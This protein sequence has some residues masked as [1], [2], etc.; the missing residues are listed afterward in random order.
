M[1]QPTN[2]VPLEHSLADFSLT[3]VSLSQIICAHSHVM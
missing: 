1:Q 3:N 2:P